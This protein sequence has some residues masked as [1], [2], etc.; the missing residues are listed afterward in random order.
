L[1]TIRSYIGGGEREIHF[2]LTS[3]MN[4]RGNEWPASHPS[5]F[6]QYAMSKLAINYT[7]AGALH[8]SDFRH[9]LIKGM[10][11][12]TFR[13]KSYKVYV[14]Y[15]HSVLSITQGNSEE[16]SPKKLRNMDNSKHI[17]Y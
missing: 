17:L 7:S 15:K 3:A 5:Y 11:N 12:I 1:C 13:K 4:G 2:F 16:V 9:F 10:A 6:S 8:L 14:K